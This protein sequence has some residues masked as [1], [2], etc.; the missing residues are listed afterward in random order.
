VGIENNNLEPYQKM[1]YYL[2]FAIFFLG[3]ANVFAQEQFS[4]YFGSDKYELNKSESGKL[5]QWLATNKDVKVIGAYGFCDEDG[6]SGYND[7]LAKKRVDF[8]FNK[9]KNKVKIREDFKS[10][11]FGKLHTMSKI[12][13]ENRKVTLYYLLPKDFAREEQIVNAEKTPETPIEKP[14][15]KP[16]VKYP[17]ELS[18]ENPD[19]S[20]T[21]FKMDTVFMKK[22][23][24]APKGQKLKIDNLNF[25]INTFAVVPESRPKLYELL[26][27]LQNNP[28][29][30]IEIQGHL[31]CNPVDKQN[32]STHR[33]RAIYNFLISNDIEKSRLS[34]KGF[35]SSE[36]LYPLPEKS[37]EERAANRRVEIMIIEN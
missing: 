18:F 30:K 21:I 13:A 17:A 5:N 15:A 6:S 22:I 29:L 26:Y 27:V 20:K 36:P 19:G 32:L 28:N 37:E 35:G 7:T 9:I 24:S 16:A 4:V 31:C 11:T 8:V 12:K 1:K 10:I 23:A 33:A 25:Y 3:I 14:K 2:L 34:Y